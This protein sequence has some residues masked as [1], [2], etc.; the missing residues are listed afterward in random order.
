MK[1]RMTIMACLLLGVM[2]AMAQSQATTDMKGKNGP[3]KKGTDFFY[4]TAADAKEGISMFAGSLAPFKEQ[5]TINL[6]L[7]VS[8][9][10]TTKQGWFFWEG[11]EENDLTEQKMDKIRKR[12]L[13]EF[14]D[15]FNSKNKKGLQLAE[16][17]KPVS[18]APYELVI[19]MRRMNTGNDSGV[20]VSNS[21]V[22][23]GG[24]VVDGTVEL[25]DM[26]TGKVLC[27]FAFNRV[28]SFFGASQRARV[29]DAM[30]TVGK[31]IG[32][33]VRDYVGK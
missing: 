10:E 18:G 13:N 28:K 23:Q 32:K 16:P 1:K 21:S 7:D 5:V 27:V 17:K 12:L 19:R 20:W 26:K 33:I 15:E 8:K 31:E 6:A 11:L 25:V 29:G 4:V 9:C 24:A 3:F 2:A 14:Q 30:G 22:K